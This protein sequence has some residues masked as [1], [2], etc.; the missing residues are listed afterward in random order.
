MRGLGA[1]WPFGS[2]CFGIFLI[3][4][5]WGHGVTL[6]IRNL[7]YI[8]G[9]KAVG[10]FE[11]GMIAL[12][13]VPETAIGKGGKKGPQVGYFAETKAFRRGLKG[14]LLRLPRPR[15]FVVER[16]DFLN[17]QFAVG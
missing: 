4:K 14:D 13:K 2:V 5:F 12:F 1:D 15:F 6:Q 16:V 11:R 7:E 3:G 8:D 17:I 10:N 9:P